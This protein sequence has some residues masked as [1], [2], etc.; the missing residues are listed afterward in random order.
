MLNKITKK[1]AFEQLNNKVQFIGSYMNIDA[2]YIN[3]FLM[4]N[5]ESQVIPYLEKAEIRE[6]V[7]QNNNQIVFKKPNRE[8]TYLTQITNSKWYEAIINNKHFIIIEGKN[9]FTICYHIVED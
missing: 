2:E 7:K 1:Y 5:Y 4:N 3:N 8:K 6:C 9:G